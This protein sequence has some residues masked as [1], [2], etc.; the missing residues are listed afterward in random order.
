MT[1]DDE[2]TCASCRWWVPQNHIP[3]SLGECR[4]SAPIPSHHQDTGPWALTSSTDW[5][6]C[7]EDTINHNTQVLKDPQAGA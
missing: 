7:W 5:C 3:G 6:R 2:W 1:N 4:F